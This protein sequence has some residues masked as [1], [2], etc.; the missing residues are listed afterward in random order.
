MA[1]I[2]QV[3]CS[4]GSGGLDT[5]P[6]KHFNPSNHGLIVER[7]VLDLLQPHKIYPI[8]ESSLNT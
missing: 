5:P 3:F 2:L 8:L 4:G 1:Q 6:F 7:N